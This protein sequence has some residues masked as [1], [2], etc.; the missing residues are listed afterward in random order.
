M[1]RKRA[2]DASFRLSGSLQARQWQKANPE[3]TYLNHYRTSARNRGQPCELTLADI[4]RFINQDCSY[5]GASPNP[6]NGIDRVD[7]TKGYILSNCVP[8]C[9]ICNR[10]KNSLTL[11]EFHQW[12]LS[13][14]N[15]LINYK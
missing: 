10:A 3:R 14:Y 12:V 7:S 8:C 1:R 2:S 13:I 15:K 5:C 4:G 11:Q 9:I 6:C